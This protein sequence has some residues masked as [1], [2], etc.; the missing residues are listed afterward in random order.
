MEAERTQQRRNSVAYAI[1]EKSM[2]CRDFCH[3]RSSQC[4]DVRDNVDFAPCSFST[5]VSKKKAKADCDSTEYYDLNCICAKPDLSAPGPDKRFIC[6]DRVDA[7]GN[8]FTLEDA[9]QL[10]KAKAPFLHNAQW[11]R[12]GCKNDGECRI[13][14]ILGACVSDVCNEDPINRVAVAKN[15]GDQD[16]S[17]SPKESADRCVADRLGHELCRELTKGEN[18]SFDPEAVMQEKAELCEDTVCEDASLLQRSEGEEVGLLQRRN[19]D[20]KMNLTTSHCS[21]RVHFCQRVCH[22]VLATTDGGK[23][24][25]MQY[26][27]NDSSFA[28]VRDILKSC[29]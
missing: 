4:V 1:L 19:V 2:S 3:N 28:H 23:R 21:H 18:C 12:K 29:C 5:N 27:D 9:I 17:R 25:C 13:D 7:A 16:P 22:S 26:C 8:A 10:C 14:F 6:D 20:V 24:K 11:D 15:A